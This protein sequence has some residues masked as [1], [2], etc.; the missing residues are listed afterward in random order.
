MRDICI[1]GGGASAM[2][3]AASA[4]A[5]NPGIKICILEK[6]ES[7]GKK[8]AATG[9]GKCNLTN[10]GC[11]GVR[12]TLEFFASI[13]IITRTDTEGRIYPYSQQA[14]EVVYALKRQLCA[15]GVEVKTGC[16]AVDVRRIADGFKVIYKEGALT[17]RH[18]L[19][20]SGGKAGPQFGTT[21]DGYAFAK[22][23]GHTVTRLSP[24]LTGLT[25]CEDLK[26]LKGIR[27]K[28]RAGLFKDGS[29]IAEE[30]G[31]VQFAGD[32]ISGILILDLSRFVKLDP[33]ENLS[34][35]FS[36]YEIKLDFLPHMSPAQVQTF[37]RERC[38]IL[39]LPAGDLLLSVVPEPLA[40]KLTM[41]AGISGGLPAEG[42]TG[43]ELSKLSK[44]LKEWRLP[45]S[46]AKGWKTAQCTSGGVALTEINLETME[47][48]LTPGLYFS[49]EIIDFDGR[50]GGFNLQ[51]AWETG[52]KAGRAMA[53]SLQKDKGG[54]RVMANVL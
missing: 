1:I 18:L 2:A 50:C 20:A 12:E 41:Q 5:E 51:N 11:A 35:G 40:K 43:T 32:G 38:G 34:E 52:I 24:V 17:A 16:P 45:L 42:I 22:A 4:A 31:E 23:M 53:V 19:L 37:L 27:V 9:N 46:G 10:A 6:M 47:S 25:I 21:G 33:E 48:L 28:A 15:L 49:G 36:R 30:N 26:A 44:M 7:L 3:A 14:R 39:K 54:S 8:L 13:G 29:L